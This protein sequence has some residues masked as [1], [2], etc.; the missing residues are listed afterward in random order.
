M[1]FIARTV[2]IAML[3]STIH[4]LCMAD[5]DAELAKKTQNPIAALISLPMQLNY[6]EDI[7]PAEQGEKWQLNVQP[8]IPISLSEDWNLISRTILPIIS[9]KDVIPGDDTQSGIGDIT[10]SLFFSPTKPTSSGWI[11]G[12]GPVL[13]LPTGRE[14]FSGEKWGLGPTAVFLKQ[15][16]GWTYGSLAN[17]IWSVAGDDDRN[18]ISATYLQP[19][20][21]YTTKTFTTFSINT[22][23]TYDWEAE[24]WSVPLN[25]SITQ[26]LKVGKQPLSLSA[27]ARYW[28]DSPDNVG[29][30]GWGFRLTGTLLFPK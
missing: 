24:E 3:T 30:E 7:G 20:L 1:T 10:Q 18:D 27:G 2:A 6:D 23:S 14:E 21:S 11:W 15:D 26:L 5:D 12:A 8:V 4:P 25:F 13:L 19:F 16:S 9:Q 28:A 22:E 17:H 29:P